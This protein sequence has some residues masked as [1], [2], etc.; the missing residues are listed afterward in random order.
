LDEPDVAARPRSFVARLRARDPRALAWLALAI[1][2]C[3]LGVSATVRTQGDFN[4]YYRT[5]N[6]V[7]HGGEIFQAADS[8]RFLYAPIYAIAIAPLAILPR[9]A[10]QFVFFAINAFALIQLVVG[11]GVMFFGR[12]QALK[13][14]LIAVPVALCFRF[15]DNNF[16]HGQVNLAVLAMVVWSIVYAG[17]DRPIL[18]GAML[19]AASLIK[20]FAWLAALCVW[21]KG[22]V[23]VF[24]AAAGAVVILLA[25]PAIF[26]GPSGCIDETL[27][28][29]STGAS[30]SERY[31]TMLTN[32]SAAAAIARLMKPAGATDSAIP[33]AARW[34]ANAVELGLVA[35]SAAMVGRFADVPLGRRDDRGRPSWKIGLAAMFCVMPGWAP[36]SWKSY[37]AALI[38]PYMA[39]V[40]MLWTDARDRAPRA[41]IAMFSLSAILN[42]APGNYLNRAALFYSAHLLSSM[43]ALGALMVMALRR[44]QAPTSEG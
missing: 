21:R 28:W 5:G 8:D 37:F 10:A 1:Y 3:A 18:S 7:L 39:L 9:H 29:I 2:L 32:Q 13:A 43:L 30:M 4:V 42:L 36:I 40:S 20:P 26:W 12:E 31:R 19:A 17:E 14:A 25:L 44:D 24:I 27:A 6:R 23:S 41:A 34:I 16:E 22:R 11:A 35:T 33:A 15:V 38:V